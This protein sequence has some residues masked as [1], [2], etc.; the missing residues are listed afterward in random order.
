[1]SDKP[2]TNTEPI[3]ID[4]IRL[5]CHRLIDAISKRPGSM[6]LLKLSERALELYSGYKLDRKYGR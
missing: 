4:E 2:E 6:K 5:R 1:M 3:S